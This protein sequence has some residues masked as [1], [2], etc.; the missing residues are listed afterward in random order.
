[1][2]DANKLTG[3][4]GADTLIGDCGLDTVSGGDDDDIIDLGHDFT[5]LDRIDGGDG[6]DTLRIDGNYSLGVT[7]SSL[8]MARVEAIEIADGNSYKFT[9]ADASNPGDLTID[10]SVLTGANWL[11]VNG[12]AEGSGQLPRHRR[13]RRR[14]PDRRQGR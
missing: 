9:L 3:G 10:G 4:K 11:F 8:T 14:H 2:A 6:T 13:H 1:M 12:A 7:F 5:A